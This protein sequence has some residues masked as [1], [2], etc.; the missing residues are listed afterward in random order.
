MYKP[1]KIIATLWWLGMMWATIACTST[2]SE[3]VVEGSVFPNTDYQKV[4][5]YHFEAKTDS[6][7]VY[8][9]NK[10]HPTIKKEKELSIEEVRTLL[11][12]VNDKR[13]YGE[14]C[15]S[16]SVERLGVVFYKEAA[17][18]AHLT[19]G[20]ACGKQLAVPVVA[21]QNIFIP[22]RQCYQS[23]GQQHLQQLCQS[24]G[25]GQCVE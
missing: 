4:V 7:L 21:A 24:L 3:K 2:T 15:D 17:V 14:Q 25:F 6:T 18:V 8:Q 9:D 16:C 1:Q 19:F 23:Y 12:W 11:Q 13:S 22:S 5:A 10:L 20:I